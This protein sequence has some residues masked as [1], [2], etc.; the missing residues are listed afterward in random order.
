M[1][2]NELKNYIEIQYCDNNLQ[3]NIFLQ[4]NCTWKKKTNLIAHN[5]R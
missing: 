4:M 1:A 5:V 3:I 2:F